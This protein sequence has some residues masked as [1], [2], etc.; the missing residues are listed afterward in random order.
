[1]LSFESA[2]SVF[3]SSLSA[4]PPVELI[5]IA[6]GKNPGEKMV[7]KFSPLVSL[8]LKSMYSAQFCGGLA[9]SRPAAV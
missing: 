3:K 5:M 1:M 2:F 9:G 8:V 7:A 4:N 6:Y